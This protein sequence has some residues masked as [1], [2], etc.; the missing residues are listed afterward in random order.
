SHRSA[1]VDDEHQFRTAVIAIVVLAHDESFRSFA[2]RIVGDI[3]ELRIMGPV[4]GRLASDNMPR[5]GS[6]SG[7][8]RTAPHHCPSNG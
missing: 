1:S 6:R 4:L 7:D 3:N 8:E 2:S 5:I